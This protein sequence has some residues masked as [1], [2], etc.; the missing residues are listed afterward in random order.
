MTKHAKGPGRFN[1]RQYLEDKM[2]AFAFKQIFIKLFLNFFLD[3]F[4]LSR[5][6]HQVFPVYLCSTVSVIDSKEE[7]VTFNVSLSLKEALN[8]IDETSQLR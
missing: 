6:K 3:F 5:K 1:L 8:K 4:M 2:S 7:Y